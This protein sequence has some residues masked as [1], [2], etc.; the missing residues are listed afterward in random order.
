MLAG[1]L[2]APVAKLARTLNEAPAKV[3]RA[4]QAVA[5]SKQ[6]ESA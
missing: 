4:I 5:D 2:K 6:G 3:A 1:T